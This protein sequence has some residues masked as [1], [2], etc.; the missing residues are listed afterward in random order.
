MKLNSSKIVQTSLFFNLHRTNSYKE[1]KTP[2]ALAQEK[3][4]N[5]DKRLLMIP[6]V[7]L[8]RLFAWNADL[9]RKGG[10]NLLTVPVV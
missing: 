8:D 1:H 2:W 5:L 9:L 3:N 10:N 4:P 6:P 7:D